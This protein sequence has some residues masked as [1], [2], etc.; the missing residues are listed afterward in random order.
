M[1]LAFP[2][3]DRYT[4]S[5]PDS[6]FIQKQPDK[7]KVVEKASKINSEF[8]KEFISNNDDYYS[9]PLTVYDKGVD[10]MRSFMYTNPAHR[11]FQT[12]SGKFS[13][14][15]S[16]RPPL[17][18][19][20]DLLPV[21]KKR[22]VDYINYDVLPEFKQ[23][24]KDISCNKD[25]QKILRPEVLNTEHTINTVDPYK[26]SFV[27][28][29]SSQ[30]LVKINPIEIDKVTHTQSKVR[31]QHDS[32]IDKE[33]QQN[34]QAQYQTNKTDG[35]RVQNADRTLDNFMMKDS[36]SAQY[37][38]NKTDGMRVQNVDRT[39][40]NFMMKD[41]TTAQYQTNKSESMRVQNVDR[42]IDN[43]MM[44]D[45]TTANFSNTKQ[46]MQNMIRH[47]SI[48]E[49][50]VKND[51]MSVDAEN[52]TLHKKRDA[53]S[54]LDNVEKFQKDLAPETYAQMQE[55]S[56]RKNMITQYENY[57]ITAKSPDAVFEGGNYRSSLRSSMTPQNVTINPRVEY[58]QHAN[59][60][61]YMP[62]N[63]RSS[64]PVYLRGKR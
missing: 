1:V 28:S 34:I 33:L 9:D 23:F 55:M 43:F 59:I 62:M 32:K 17:I 37:Q 45:P 57:E 44:K 24:L 20:T 30:Q 49:R 56:K 2:K 39:L 41:P 11:G 3:T 13:I 22:N 60:G 36:A 58:Q 19:G 6:I 15:D 35:M 47:D 16:F 25:L 7:Y 46:Y 10:P 42:S 4:L 29:N 27:T 51:L 26:S 64:E 53:V 21:W 14:N 31:S 5:S 50:R 61:G 12:G 63:S 38:T 40:D 54:Y 48:D 8:I 18:T 52:Y